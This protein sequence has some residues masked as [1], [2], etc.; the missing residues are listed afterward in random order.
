VVIIGLLFKIQHWKLATEF[1]TVGL[2][3]EALLFF[4]L[5]FQREDKDIDWVR[6]YPEWTKILRANCQK[7]LQNRHWH[8]RLL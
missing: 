8:Q 3:A 7:H 6:V 5:G 1:I 2:S 4:I